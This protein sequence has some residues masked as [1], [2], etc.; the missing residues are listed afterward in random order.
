MCLAAALLPPNYNTALHG[1]SDTIATLTLSYTSFI[2]PPALSRIP[3]SGCYIVLDLYQHAGVHWQNG[4]RSVDC[5]SLPD[6]TADNYAE[7]MAR[8]Q[9]VHALVNTHGSGNVFSFFMPNG[10]ALV[11]ILPYNFHGKHCTWADQYYR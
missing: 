3:Q 2:S 11:E 4:C 1:L 9:T 8:L 7:L 6:G 10:S 5:V